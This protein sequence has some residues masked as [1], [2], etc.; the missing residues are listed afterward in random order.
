MLGALFAMWT[1]AFCFFPCLDFLYKCYTWRAAPC[2]HLFEIPAQRCVRHCIGLVNVSKS[3]QYRLGRFIYHNF[4]SILRSFDD[5]VFPSYGG[6]L[7]RVKGAWAS[8]STMMYRHVIW[9]MSHLVFVP[10]GL[11]PTWS[12][13]LLKC[14]TNVTPISITKESMTANLFYISKGEMRYQA[15]S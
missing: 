9:S 4:P 11:C 6:N 14:A 7:N 15:N 10:L 2:S 8:A 1:H 13:R 5:T 12:L 3:I